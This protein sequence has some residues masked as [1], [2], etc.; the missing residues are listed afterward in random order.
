MERRNPNDYSLRGT[1]YDVHD[2]PLADVI[3]QAY[4]KDLRTQ[5]LLG[6]AKT[7]QN[8]HYEI[9]Y[10]VAE[11]A[12]AEN[13]DDGILSPDVF[14]LV[15]SSGT[16][17]PVELGESEIYYNVHCHINVGCDLSVARARQSGCRF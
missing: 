8:G 5:Q 15:H 13:M 9:H 11:F 16:G 6:R 12:S 10:S 4:D 2:T 7:D 3:V 17:R 1:I 14:L